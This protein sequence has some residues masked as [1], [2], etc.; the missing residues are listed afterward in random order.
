M[1]LKTTYM[2]VFSIRYTSSRCIVERL[3]RSCKRVFFSILG[4][5]LLTDEILLTVFC[6]F[7]QTLNA[8]P[9]SPVSSDPN[10]TD[11]MM[12]NQFFFDRPNSGL[13]PTATSAID[14]NHP[15]RYAR[16]QAYA[17]S[18]WARWLKEYFPFLNRRNKWATDSSRAL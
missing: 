15:K 18:I 5:R 10:D 8:R 7:E 14:F 11:A 9:L 17:D 16:A 4:D 12:P 1:V 13:L 2:E 3:V 6:L